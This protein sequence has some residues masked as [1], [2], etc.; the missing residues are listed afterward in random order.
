MF[1]YINADFDG[2]EITEESMSNLLTERFVNKD[3]VYAAIEEL[4]GSKIPLLKTSKPMVDIRGHLSKSVIDNAVYLSK[5]PNVCGNC[6]SDK[7]TKRC[8]ACKRIKYCSKACQKADWKK[9]K[10]ICKMLC[11]S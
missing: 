6:L 8:G 5:L 11:Q 10:N 2:D 9:H 7:T 1:K 4:K 3:N